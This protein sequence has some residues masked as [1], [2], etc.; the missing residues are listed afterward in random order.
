VGLGEDWGDFKLFINGVNNRIWWDDQVAHP[1][2]LGHG[3]F[4]I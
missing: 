3:D 2:L 4:S 1:V